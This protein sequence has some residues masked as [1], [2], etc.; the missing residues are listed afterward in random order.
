[1]YP[2]W[3]DVMRPNR[4]QYQL[5]FT[6]HCV[7]LKLLR[8]VASCH[9]IYVGHPIGLVCIAPVLAAKVL[10]AEVTMGESGGELGCGLIETWLTT[11]VGDIC[12]GNSEE[13]LVGFCTFIP[14]FIY[15][16]LKLV[17]KFLELAEEIKQSF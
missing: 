3:I 13:I 7:L 9:I 1:M 16:L 4:R 17:W 11:C 8:V 14:E 12:D 10:N 6:H 5:F 2:S 15:K